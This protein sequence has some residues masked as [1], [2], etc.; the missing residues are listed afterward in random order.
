MCDQPLAQFL[1]AGSAM[2]LL[3]MVMAYYFWRS[4]RLAK[5]LQQ[6]ELRLSASETRFRQMIESMPVGLILVR[7]P[8]LRVTFIN[9]LAAKMLNMPQAAALSMRAFQFYSDKTQFIEQI[10]HADQQA[11]ECILKRNDASQFWASVSMAAIS[12]PEH[13]TLLI[14]INDISQRK[15]LEEQ[16]KHR[17]TIDSLSGLCNRAY[18]IELSSLEIQR[19]QRYKLKACIL[20]LD[21][22]FFKR[23]ND[24]YGHHAGDLVIQAMAKLCK[25]TLREVDIIGRL[26]GEEFAAFLP[27][28]RLDAAKLAAE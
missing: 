5:N 24:S 8:D 16:L 4:Q 10:H 17:A 2:L 25:T 27:E 19:M 15:N 20:M 22:D 7:K 3:A 13:E 1:I 6:K 9:R 18:F 23:V 26:G 12:M 21:L 14:G 11:Y 28:T